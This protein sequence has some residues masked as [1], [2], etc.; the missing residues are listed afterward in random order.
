MFIGP[1]PYSLNHTYLGMKAQEERMN[2]TANIIAN[3][4]TPGFNK[5]VTI[6][7]GHLVT[8]SKT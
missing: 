2:L 7:E 6:A 1:Y 3:V 8:Q 5:D 4:N